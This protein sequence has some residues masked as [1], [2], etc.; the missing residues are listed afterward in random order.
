MSKSFVVG[1]LA[2]AIVV[3]AGG[4]AAGY[5]MYTTA[6]SA[7][8]LSAKALTRKLRIPRQECHDETVTHTKP[9]KD[10]Q[11]LL[12]TGLGAL[13][14]GVLGHQ[15][16]GGSGKTLATVAGAA[17]GGYAGN[18]IQQRTQ[19]GDTYTSTEQRCLTAY[20]IKE[21]PAGFEVVYE[22][23]GKQHRVHTDRDPGPALPVKDGKV[24]V[25]SLN[26]PPDATQ[27][28]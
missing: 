16:G 11:R 21:Q 1:A 12:G 13:V 5:K 22:Y 10:R 19:Q 26:T 24:D 4:A 14:G 7:T 17:A 15:V 23:K 2:G 28:S 25:A 3:T 20:D 6:H 18:K 27:G 8:V 9:V